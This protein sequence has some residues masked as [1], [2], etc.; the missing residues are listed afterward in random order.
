M[1]IANELLNFFVNEFENFE[2]EKYFEYFLIFIAS[3]SK[4]NENENFKKILSEKFPILFEK[5]KNEKLTYLK[6]LIKLYSYNIDF[7]NK[8]NFSILNNI[9][10]NN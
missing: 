7:D 8:E 3:I 6:G 10:K 5:I 1:F 9:L 2:K 4:K